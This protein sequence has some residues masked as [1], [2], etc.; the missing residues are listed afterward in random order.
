LI[1]HL[2]TLHR[3]GSLIDYDT[4]IKALKAFVSNY[5]L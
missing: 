5:G 2:I 3:A 4:D 1:N